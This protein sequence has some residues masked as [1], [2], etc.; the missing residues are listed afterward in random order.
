MINIKKS[1]RNYITK[2]IIFVFAYLSIHVS[3]DY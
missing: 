1:F 2:F 3:T